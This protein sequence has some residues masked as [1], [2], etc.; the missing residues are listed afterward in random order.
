MKS[1]VKT[2]LLTLA[3]GACALPV[4]RA[5]D[6]TPT[7]TPPPEHHEKGHHFKDREDHMAK[8]LGL[9]ADQ[10]TQMKA[11]AEE[12][13]K[14]ADAVRADASLTSEQ[15][16]EKVTQ[17]RLDYK[18]R[19]QALLTPEQQKKAE[20]MKAKAKERRQSHGEEAAGTENK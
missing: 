4:I 3:A 9:T 7:D 11:L 8:E 15:K 17:I 6:T 19:R 18:A 20:E 2:F 16:R 13:R 10:Q 12:Q 14:A 5:E 1:F